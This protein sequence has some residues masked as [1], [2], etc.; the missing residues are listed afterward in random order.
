MW[1]ESKKKTLRISSC[2]RLWFNQHVLKV[3]AWWRLE[4]KATSGK[5][6]GRLSDIVPNGGC[7]KLAFEIQN[8]GKK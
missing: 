8:I 4:W 6:T 2:V 3:F 7:A 5:Q 1:T